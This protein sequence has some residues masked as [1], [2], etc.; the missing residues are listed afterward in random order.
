MV[1]TLNCEYSWDRLAPP[2]PTAESI[3][4]LDG[5]GLR[6]RPAQRSARQHYLASPQVCSTLIHTWPLHSLKSSNRIELNLALFLQ[7]FRSILI[8]S[9]FI[10]ILILNNILNNQI[11]K[12]ACQIWYRRSGQI[13]R[14]EKFVLQSSGFNIHITN[15][16]VSSPSNGPVFCVSYF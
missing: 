12:K 6:P 1:S 8:E 14:S 5:I 15:I 3:L 10:W 13:F 7:L 2:R 11:S 16:W 9:S 4:T